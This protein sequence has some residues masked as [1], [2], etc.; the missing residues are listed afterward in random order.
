MVKRGLYR[1]N[2]CWNKDPGDPCTEIVK[3]YDIKEGLVRC[4]VL[5]RKCNEMTDKPCLF[6]PWGL[7]DW[8]SIH[9]TPIKRTDLLLYMTMPFVSDEM[10]HIIKGKL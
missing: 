2:F 5:A 4:K 9:P 7:K 8:R 10:R 1:L 6:H 3:V